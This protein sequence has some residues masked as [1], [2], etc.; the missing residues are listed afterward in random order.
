MAEVN[1]VTIYATPGELMTNCM[2]PVLTCKGSIC[3][4]VKW[5]NIAFCL[6]KAV[7]Y[8]SLLF[9]EWTLRSKLR[10]CYESEVLLPMQM[11]WNESGFRPPLCTYRL[12]WARRTFW[13]WWDEWDDT[14]LQTQ[15]SKFEPWWSEATT[16]APPPP[17]PNT[18]DAHFFLIITERILSPAAG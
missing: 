3:L 7:Y 10:H 6:R 4:P 11:K 5:A 17:P 13:G 18:A 9:S 16:L 14:V 12:N 2:Q 15:D 8:S 1:I